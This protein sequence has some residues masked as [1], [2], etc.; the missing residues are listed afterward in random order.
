MGHPDAGSTSA[1]GPLVLG[2]AMTGPGRDEIAPARPT[3]R[4]GLRDLPRARSRAAVA[5]AGRC[6]RMPSPT[7]SARGY[8]P[9]VVWVFEANPPARRFYEAAGFRTTAPAH[10][11]DFDGTP[12]DEIRY[13]LADRWRSARPAAAPP[14]ARPDFV[15][16]H[17]PGSVCAGAFDRPLN[18][19]LMHQRSISRRSEGPDRPS[20][21]P[22]PAG[23]GS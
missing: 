7:S 23:V 18:A 20:T 4:R 2:F 15:R 11:I 1:D 13:R 9:I 22:G 21:T 19:R 12:I 3:V 8:D 10:T 17:Q 14:E 6:S 16:S 5:T